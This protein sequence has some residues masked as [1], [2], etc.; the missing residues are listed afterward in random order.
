MCGFKNFVI[1]DD[2]LDRN[3]VHEFLL[4]F[5]QIKNIDACSK[6]LILKEGIILPTIDPIS[7]DI[8]I[9]EN[10]RFNHEND[11]ESSQRENKSSL[12]I[13]LLTPSWR[14]H[15]SKKGCVCYYFFER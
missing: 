14:K 3:H 9:V 15:Q 12:L 5:D 8:D 11:L 7:P 2:F 1:L 6:C 4:K 13:H 10:Y